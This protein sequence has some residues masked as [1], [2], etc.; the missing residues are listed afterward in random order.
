LEPQA[1]TLN[2]VTTPPEELVAGHGRLWLVFRARHG[3]PHHLA[4]G[5]PFDLGRDEMDPAVRDWIAV[6]S[7]VEVVTF[8]GLTVMRFV[9]KGP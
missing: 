5:E 9:G 6:H 1:V 4:W 2:Q 3:D 7:P 8:P